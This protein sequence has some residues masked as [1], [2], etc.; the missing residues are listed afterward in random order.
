ME[1]FL[2]Q[3][4]SNALAIRRERAARLLELDQAVGE[5]VAALKTRGFESPYL[6]AFVLARINPLRFTLK[7]GQKADF[8]ETMTKMLA[9]ARKFDAG[10]IRSDQVARAAGAPDE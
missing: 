3:K 4:L 2:P 7:R 5:A 6:K 1:S 8:D 10:K 9:S